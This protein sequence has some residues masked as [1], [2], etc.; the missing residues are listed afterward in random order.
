MIGALTGKLLGILGEQRI[1]F[2]V[3]DV[4]YEIS[5][6]RSLLPRLQAQHDVQGATQALLYVTT[7]VR[8]NDLRLFGFGELAA[9]RLFELLLSISGV[10][11]QLS[12]AIIDSMNSEDFYRKVYAGETEALTRIKGIGK[13]TAERLVLE[14]RDKIPTVFGVPARI[15]RQGEAG[16]PR[17]GGVASDVLEALLGLGYKRYEASAV[18]EE[19]KGD[20]LATLEGALREAL[21]LLAKRR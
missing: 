20:K 9:K 6:P 19:I 11:P 15:S 21:T 18:I 16:E 14:L 1:L 2:D 12:L 8:E 10:G 4:A 3:H 7:Y 17:A 5:V 13:K